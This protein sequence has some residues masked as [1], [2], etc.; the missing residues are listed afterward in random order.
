RE[1]VGQPLAQGVREVRH[2][3]IGGRPARHPLP[4]LPGAEGR[5]AR[6][7][8]HLVEKLEVHRDQCG[9][10]RA[11][12]SRARTPGY[13]R[14][15]VAS[16]ASSVRPIPLGYWASPRPCI[17]RPPA[18]PRARALPRPAPTVSPWDSRR[19]GPP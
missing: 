16:A 17:A 19:T 12:P 4:H 18:A 5:L 1:L 8:E 14:A 6:A 10:P 15:G 7:V 2:L 13:D 3:R 11:C 9:S